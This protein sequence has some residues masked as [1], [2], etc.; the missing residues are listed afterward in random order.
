MSGNTVL[1]N[2]QM[3]SFLK[4]CHDSNRFKQ[5]EMQQAG[6]QTSE[7]ARIL[8]VH[9]STV[10]RLQRRPQDTEFTTDKRRSGRPRVTT[11]RQDRHIVL[12]H[13]RNRF[14]SA[15]QAATEI[16]GGRISDQTVR[17]RL[18]ERGL[19]SCRPLNAPHSTDRQRQNRLNWCREHQAWIRATWKRILWTDE[20]RFQCFL[21][22]G[23]QRVWRRRGERYHDVA[24]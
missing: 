21:A 10:S 15:T 12:S 20:S 24:V 22:D 2:F 8:G 3:L 18:K 1:F 16:R 13:L 5:K 11:Q 17:N 7:V 14:L 19:N 4:P 9:R 6:R 23:R